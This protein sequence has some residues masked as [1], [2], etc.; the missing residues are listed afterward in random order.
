[1]AV[2]CFT[3]AAETGHARANFNLGVMYFSGNDVGK[4]AKLAVKC[5]TA[6]AAEAGKIHSSIVGREQLGEEE[7]WDIQGL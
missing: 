3:A 6:A 5:F 1:M 2:K 7:D 4:D